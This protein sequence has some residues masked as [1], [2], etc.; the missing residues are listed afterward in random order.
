MSSYELAESYVFGKQS[1]T[2]I[3]CDPP[4]IRLQRSTPTRRPPSPEVTGLI[5]QVP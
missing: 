1:P 2:P 3:S 4:Q 5:C